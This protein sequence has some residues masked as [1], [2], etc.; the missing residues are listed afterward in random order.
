MK[1]WVGAI[2][3]SPPGFGFHAALVV[4]ALL[5]L[6]AFSFPGSNFLLLLFVSPWLLL[7]AVIWLIRTI[8][9]W[10]WP[11][12]PPA[13]SRRWLFVSPLAGVLAVTLLW[14]HVPLT[15]RFAHAK[16]SFETYVPPALADSKFND[17]TSHHIG[18]YNIVQIYRNLEAVIFVEATGNFMDDA[19]FAYLP[20]GPRPGLGN[21]SFEAPQFV[22][23]SGQWYAWTASW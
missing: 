5:I 6:W 4:P 19:G 2:L 15:L 21:G 9:C 7:A 10:R 1:L 16:T 14:A 3:R 22:H 13:R 8:A 17:I 23:L 18:T 11:L 12:D 20:R